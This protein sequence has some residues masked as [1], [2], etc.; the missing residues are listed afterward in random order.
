M[1][2]DKDTCIFISGH[3][4]LLGSAI[5][6][7]LAKQGYSNLVVRTHS[8]LDFVDQAATNQFFAEAKPDYVFHCAAKIGG[9][10]AT[11]EWQADFL[12][13]NTM[14]AANVIKAA[15]DC[16]VKQMI[17]PGSVCCFPKECPTPI[18]E[19]YVLTGSFEPTC[20]GY[21][22]AKMTAQMMMKYFNEQ[23]GTNFLTVNLCNLWGMNDCF[24]QS[25]NHVIPALLERIHDAKMNGD[26]AVTCYGT[27]NAK[28]EF[29]YADDA[30]EGLVRLMQCT[31]VSQYTGG[32]INLGGVDSVS[33]KELAE[34]ICR[35]VDY[36]GE[37]VWDCSKPDGVL[38]RELDTT[39]LRT[40]MNWEPKVSLEEGIRKVYASKF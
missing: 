17:I 35:I 4:G 25:R 33:I 29:L 31:S 18:K 22:M 32:C 40:V 1:M 39:R 30:A 3:T 8:E 34:L 2:T 11:N 5:C 10:T 9:I 15:Y 23:Y 20:E 14:I 27:G 12:Y 36:D 19:E 6:R 26:K 38:R 16:G 24:D 13:E 37:I 21:A 28:R 7:E